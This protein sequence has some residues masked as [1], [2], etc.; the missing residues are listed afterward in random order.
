MIEAARIAPRLASDTQL[1]R[2]PEY[3]ELMEIDENTGDLPVGPVRQQFAA[4]YL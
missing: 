2:S 1:K 3:I 4:S